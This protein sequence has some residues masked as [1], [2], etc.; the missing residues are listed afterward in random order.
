M[1]EI[2][3]T[4]EGIRQAT[5]LTLPDGTRRPDH[6]AIDRL[7]VRLAGT[8]LPPGCCWIDTPGINDRAEMNAAAERAA[9]VADIVV[10]VLNEQQILAQC[11][12]DFIGAFVGE[13]GPRSVVFVLNAFLKG[14]GIAGDAL[15]AEWERFRTHRLPR[16]IAKIRD[17][18]EYM[19]FDAD[20]PPPIV[21]VCAVRLAD[22][23]AP[24]AAALRALIADLSSLDTERVLRTRC[25][26]AALELRAHAAEAAAIGAKERERCTEER[27]QQLQRAQTQSDA[28]RVE[29]TAAVHRFVDGCAFRFSVSSDRAQ[30]EFGPAAQTHEGALRDRL[31]QLLSEDRQQEFSGL[32]SSL[33][34]AA[35]YYAQRLL[36]PKSRRRACRCMSWRRARSAPMCRATR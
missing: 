34:L 17:F 32:L 8:N 30:A 28:F 27:A 13:R 15:S 36:D 35:Q 11:E 26:R 6:V 19:G 4:S 7:E 14:D 24:E 20:L 2:P 23:R 33:D 29:A 1:Q 9:R 12:M 18:G 22:S 25:Y 16:L 10:W 31:R 5:S 21:P 3:C